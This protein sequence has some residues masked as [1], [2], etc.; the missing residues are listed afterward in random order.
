MSPCAARARYNVNVSKA[1]NARSEGIDLGPKASIA[2]GWRDRI[3]PVDLNVEI[4][5]NG[6]LGFL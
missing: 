4:E 1:S 5:S 6:L 2:I 3:R